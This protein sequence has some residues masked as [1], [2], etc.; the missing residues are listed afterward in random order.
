MG[1]F[2]GT[3]NEGLETVNVAFRLIMIF[4]PNWSNE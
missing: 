2:Q 4:P 3:E 1:V